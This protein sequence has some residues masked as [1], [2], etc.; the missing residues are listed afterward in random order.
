MLLYIS[1]SYWVLSIRCLDQ[2]KG[3]R[4]THISY[5]DTVNEPIA[6]M[7]VKMVLWIVTVSKEFGNKLGHRDIAV[8]AS[9]YGTKGPGFKTWWSQNDFIQKNI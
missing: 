3:A 1:T 5:H 2:L 6:W 4:H 8:M 7:E 9:A